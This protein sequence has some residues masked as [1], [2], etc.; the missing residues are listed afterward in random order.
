MS[1]IHEEANTQLAKRQIE[2]NE[3]TYNNRMETLFVFQVLFI[4]IM[5][6]AILMYLKGAGFL[7][8]AFMAYVVLL[9][10]F[11]VVLI[12]VNRSMYT[13]RIRDPR[14]WHRRRF[15]DDN[16]M[17]PPSGF[18]NQAYKAYLAEIRGQDSNSV[19]SKCPK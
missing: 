19:C 17:L 3:W 16:K 7:S 6:V 5:I 14:S 8:G 9:L 2:I 13:N 10:T 12:I 18:D 1:T 4:S 15:D 11:I